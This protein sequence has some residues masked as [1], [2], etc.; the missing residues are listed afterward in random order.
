[1][2][3]QMSVESG[4]SSSNEDSPEQAAVEVQEGKNNFLGL[5]FTFYYIR[6]LFI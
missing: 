3:A 1:M 6:L 4:Q 2:A 5:P